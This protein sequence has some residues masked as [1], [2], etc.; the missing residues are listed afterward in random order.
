MV[1]TNSIISLGTSNA[2]NGKW[3]NTKP[4]TDGAIEVGK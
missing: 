1:K 2:P 4:D 3:C